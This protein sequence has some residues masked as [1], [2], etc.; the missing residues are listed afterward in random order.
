[1]QIYVPDIYIYIHMY[2]YVE[3]RLCLCLFFCLPA[4]G[5]V[6]SDLAKK[7]SNNNCLCADNV[8]SYVCECVQV[9]V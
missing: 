9:C 2:L 4:C 6:K 8:L 3:F 5:S 7:C 1:M